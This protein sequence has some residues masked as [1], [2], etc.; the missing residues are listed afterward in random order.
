MDQKTGARFGGRQLVLEWVLTE[1]S[2]A[3][4]PRG[5]SRWERTAGRLCGEG[6]G[7]QEPLGVWGN[8]ALMVFSARF[9]FRVQSGASSS[10]PGPSPVSR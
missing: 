10:G 8:R 6:G 1:E 5:R 9:L 3:S 4:D 7:R 2:D